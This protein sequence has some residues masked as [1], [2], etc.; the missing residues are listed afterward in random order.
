MRIEYDPKHDI[1][2]IE[3]L[4]DEEIADSVEN[5]GIIFDYSKDRKIVSLEILDVGKRISRKPLEMVDFAVVQS[6][7]EE[8]VKV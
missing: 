2:N 7:E 6:K 5:E 3:F 4:V 8:P 1:M